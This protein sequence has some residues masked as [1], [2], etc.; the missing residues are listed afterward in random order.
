MRFRHMHMFSK[1]N[2]ILTIFCSCI[3]GLQ[4]LRA[5]KYSAFFAETTPLPPPRLWML[6]RPMQSPPQKR[7]CRFSLLFGGCWRAFSPRS[8]ISSLFGTPRLLR[9]KPLV[10]SV[11]L[12]YFCN[13]AVSFPPLPQAHD[14]P[15]ANPLLFCCSCRGRCRCRP[16]RRARLAT[17]LFRGK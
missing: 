10:R 12:H 17:I 5:L 4:Y 3:W 7:A 2:R 1:Q 13:F 8:S 14:L 9:V 6:Q 11:L 15:F 16:G